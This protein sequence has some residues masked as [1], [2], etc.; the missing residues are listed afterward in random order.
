LAKRRQRS[1]EPATRYRREQ[2]AKRA[3]VNEALIATVVAPQ[4]P[5]PMPL[6]A[7]AAGRDENE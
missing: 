1:A 5:S 7:P 2:L 3:V 6:Q 4:A